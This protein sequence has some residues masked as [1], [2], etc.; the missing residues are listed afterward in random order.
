MHLHLACAAARRIVRRHDIG[1]Q[2]PRGAELSDLHEVVRTDRHRETQ[3]RSDLIDAQ[4]LLHQFH[5]VFVAGSQRKG[6][7]L[8]DR[9]TAVMEN[10][11]ADV[12]KTNPLVCGSLRDQRRQILKTLALPVLAGHRSFQRQLFDDRVE[13]ERGSHRFGIDSLLIH[14]IDKKARYFFGGAAAENELGIFYRNPG[15]QRIEVGCGKLLVPDHE[16]D[17]FD[18]FGQQDGSLCIG[19]FRTSDLDGLDDPPVVV[20]PGTPYVRKFPALRTEVLDA[21]EIL[22]AVVRAD[23]ESLGRSP[24]EFFLIIGPFKVYRDH[25]FP[26]LGRNRR[27]FGEQLLFLICHSFMI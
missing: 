18:P 12:D 15:Q 24:H 22:G 8:H 5:H 16:T 25:R 3:R 27:K 23:I 4:A 9:G 10:L 17:R 20:F 6:Q 14:F 26:L 21:V 19:L 7:F 13:H 2:Q 1:P 11:A